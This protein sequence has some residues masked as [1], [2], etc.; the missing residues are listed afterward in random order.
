M[1]GG[2]GES[3][4]RSNQSVDG[5]E[6]HPS[7]GLPT[8]KMCLGRSGQGRSVGMGHIGHITSD[9]FQGRAHGSDPSVQADTRGMLDCVRL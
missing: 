9:R 5:R 3:S 7:Q 1:W 8:Q 6:R 4:P 2:P